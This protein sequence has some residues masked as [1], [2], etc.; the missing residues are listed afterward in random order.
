MYAHY[1]FQNYLINFNLKNETHNHLKMDND[2][3]L[4]N[5]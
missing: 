3:Y 1:T 2:R 4:V 5:I